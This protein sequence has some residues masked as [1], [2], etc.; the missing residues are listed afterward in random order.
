MSDLEPMPSAQ[1]L[2]EREINALEESRD[3]LPPGT[4]VRALFDIALDH[5]EMCAAHL[6]RSI[7]HGPRPAD[8]GPA[9][10]RGSAKKP[11]R[12]TLSASR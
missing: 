1:R 2:I 12:T 11:S 5:L 4:H 8:S 3:E 7:H 10:A 9:Q 6:Q